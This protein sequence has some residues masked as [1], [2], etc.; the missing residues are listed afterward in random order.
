[1]LVASLKIIFLNVIYQIY[2]Q[3]QNQSVIV[4]FPLIDKDKSLCMDFEKLLKQGDIHDLF[5]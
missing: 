1:M 2:I 5:K 4:R 3:Q